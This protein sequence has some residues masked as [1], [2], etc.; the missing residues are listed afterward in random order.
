MTV[1]GDLLSKPGRLLK[2]V[3]GILKF[4]LR[5]HKPFIVPIELIHL[6]HSSGGRHTVPDRRFA[7][8]P[9]RSATRSF[10][11]LPLTRPRVARGLRQC[12]CLRNYV[13][14][15]VNDSAV[16][17]FEKGLGIG[18]RNLCLPFG[19]GDII[20]RRALDCEDAGTIL[21]ADA[22]GVSVITGNVTLPYAVGC[23]GLGLEGVT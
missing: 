12:A 4:N 6:K 18:K 21:Y 13:P 2:G 9:R 3:I 22:D 23:N 7:T 1:S 11:P 5:H 16:A 10:G 15:L 8:P 20:G 14:G 17:E 19:A